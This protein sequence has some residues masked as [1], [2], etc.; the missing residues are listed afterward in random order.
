[1]IQ[2]RG[3][4]PRPFLVWGSPAAHR[5]HTKSTLGVLGGPLWSLR[6][7]LLDHALFGSCEPL[8]RSVPIRV[9]AVNWQSDK[10]Y[11][12]EHIVW[13]PSRCKFIGRKGIFLLDRVCGAV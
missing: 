9:I 5:E 10:R 11:Q 2:G 7:P 4:W 12:S 1:M 8:W 3:F 6:E 13:Y